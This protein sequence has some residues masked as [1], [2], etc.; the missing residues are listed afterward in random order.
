M[1]HSFPPCYKAG[2]LQTQG[3]GVAGVEEDEEA[4]IAAMETQLPERADD[5]KLPTLP[6]GSELV[7]NIYST[8]GDVH[9]VGLTGIQVCTL[10]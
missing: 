5:F 2:R 8:W 4:A 3:A 9:Y 10:G 6:S 1:L 7:L